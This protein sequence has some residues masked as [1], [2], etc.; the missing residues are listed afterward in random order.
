MGFKTEQQRKEYNKQ[1]YQKTR[2]KQL[3]DK[4]EY[5]KLNKERISQKNKEYREKNKDK[6]KEYRR[7]WYNKNKDTKVKDYKNSEK[8]IKTITKSDW[9]RQRLNMD[10]FDE[11]YDR[12][13]TI[14]NCEVC[15][16]MLTK[17][18]YIRP[19]TKCMDHNHITGYYRHTICNSCNINRGFIDANYLKVIKE[20]KNICKSKNVFLKLCDN[21]N[22]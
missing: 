13:I 9:K 14:T 1:Y 4:K 6:L 16:C 10:Y 22:G 3:E 21:I 2:L 17:D 19:T 20:F 12:H 5:A 18:K 15:N 8:G 11:I 7:E